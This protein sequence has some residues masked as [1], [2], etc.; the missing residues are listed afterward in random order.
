MPK[1]LQFYLAYKDKS[2]VERSDGG[3]KLDFHAVRQIN[4]ELLFLYSTQM[5]GNEDVYLLDKLPSRLSSR[6]KLHSPAV[7]TAQSLQHSREQGGAPVSL[8]PSM[9]NAISAGGHFSAL[10]WHQSMLSRN[11]K[12]KICPSS[13]HRRCSPAPSSISSDYMCAS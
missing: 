3:L 9:E 6:M 1:I 11:P 4:F 7:L 12:S 2:S 5:L 8:P 13:P 10:G